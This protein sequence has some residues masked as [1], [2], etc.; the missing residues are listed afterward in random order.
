MHA[1]A[2]Y[3]Q[4]LL[5]RRVEPSCKTPKPAQ[6]GSARPMGVQ[7]GICTANLPCPAPFDGAATCWSA[8]H[9]ADKAQCKNE[10]C[11]SA[12]V[13][14]TCQSEH[15]LVVP[16]CLVGFQGPGQIL[17][18]HEGQGGVL[19]QVALPQHLPVHPQ[20][21]LAGRLVVPHQLQQLPQQ[22]LQ[23]QTDWIW[24]ESTQVTEGRVFLQI[25]LAQ[26]FPIQPQHCLT[27]CVLSS[28]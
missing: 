9:E 27:A 25:V 24:E 17:S 14:R 23:A 15:H 3:E 18:R 8:V 13:R 5:I 21:C 22:A 20:H 12:R 1:T 4:Q 16:C 28:A 6:W 19:L 2:V 10:R 7:K 26:H 11:V